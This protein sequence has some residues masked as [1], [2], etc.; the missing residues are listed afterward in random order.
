M[1][2]KKEIEKLRMRKNKYQRKG[3]LTKMM[4][5]THRNHKLKIRSYKLSRESS[6][7]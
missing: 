1:H 6:N 2:K 4:I 7:R 5:K 3:K